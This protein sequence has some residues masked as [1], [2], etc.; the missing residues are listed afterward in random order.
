MEFLSSLL[1]DVVAN[2]VLWRDIV[3]CCGSADLARIL[4]VHTVNGCSMSLLPEQASAAHQ[5]HQF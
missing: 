2:V 3:K 1:S 5:E 4:K